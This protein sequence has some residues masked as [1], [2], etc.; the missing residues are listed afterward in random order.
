MAHRDDCQLD[1]ARGSF[2][3]YGCAGRGQGATDGKQRLVPSHSAG[4][5]WR[6]PP[7]PVFRKVSTESTLS[8]YAIETHELEDLDWRHEL[9]ENF[10][11]SIFVCF[12]RRSVLPV[13]LFSV[14]PR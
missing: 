4:I 10:V 5:D 9:L 13:W 14:H 1:P 3:G 6:Q 2:F 11:Q 12:P 7:H 8:H